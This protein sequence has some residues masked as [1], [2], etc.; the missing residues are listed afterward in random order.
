[1]DWTGTV[2]FSFLLQSENINSEEIVDV[3]FLRNLYV[4][5]WKYFLFLPERDL[6]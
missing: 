5:N 4:S 1:M 6:V 2:R 3:L